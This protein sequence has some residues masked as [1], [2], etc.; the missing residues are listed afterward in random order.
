MVD[1][2]GGLNYDICLSAKPPMKRFLTMRCLR[3]ALL[4]LCLTGGLPCQAASAKAVLGQIDLSALNVVRGEVA[5][6]DGEW[7]F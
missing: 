6:L 3:F 7:A 5:T 2:C 1:A 4:C